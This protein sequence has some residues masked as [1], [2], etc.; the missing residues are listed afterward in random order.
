MEKYDINKKPWHS[1]KWWMAVIG[2]VIPLVNH[3]FGM[4]LNPIEISAVLAPIIAYLLGQS[5]VDSKH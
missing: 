3:F 1:K 2:I 5:Y 4:G